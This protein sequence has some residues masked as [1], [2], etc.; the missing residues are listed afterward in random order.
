MYAHFWSAAVYT[1]FFLREQQ[2]ILRDISARDRQ[3]GTTVSFVGKGM[4]GEKRSLAILV[5]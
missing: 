1:V 5:P 4:A 3:S 2:P